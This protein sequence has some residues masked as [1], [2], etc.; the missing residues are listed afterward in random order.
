LTNAKE[1]RIVAFHESGHAIVAELAAAWAVHKVSIAA[2]PRPPAMQRA[3]GSN[4]LRK[5]S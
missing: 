3:G 1:R 4:L 2:R 5:T